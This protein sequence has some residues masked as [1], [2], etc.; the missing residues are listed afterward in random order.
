MTKKATLANYWH[1]IARGE[2]VTDQPKPFR[3]LGERLVAF[4]DE[5]GVAVFKDLCVHRGT[6]LSL[7]C[8]SNGRL[9]CAYH[10]WQYDRTGACV[11]I[12][13]LPE[14]SAIPRK[15]RAIVYRA[16][17]VYGLVWVA[18]DE[19]VQ[20]IPAW[21][22]EAWE[23]SDYRV[24]L[25][26]CYVWKG[27]AGRATE[28]ALD[29][30]H[31]NFVHRGIT[32]LADGPTIKSYEVRETDSG[33][34]YAYEDG[35][36]RREYTLCTP[37][38]LHDKKFVVEASTGGTWSEAKAQKGDSTILT[39]IAAPTDTARTHLYVFVARNHSLDVADREFTKGFDIVME[40]DQRIV[41]SQR[42]E[43]I[44]TDLRDE[45][46]LR[47]PDA[48]GVAYRRLLGRI[49]KIEPFLP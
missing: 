36:L 49:K 32:E 9:T 19:P 13:S 27:S 30:A 3:L 39:F 18:M 1:P 2:D 40:Q 31:F 6:A 33:L 24:F 8:V 26:G 17:E 41:E 45:L 29:F 43:E 16:A 4:R 35:R 25:A 44:P 28:N 48:S 42:P 34:E 38:T 37:F 12:P 15:A 11:H 21:P 46:H 7:G 10:G 20:P 22:D 23:N 47:V 14:G 5:Q